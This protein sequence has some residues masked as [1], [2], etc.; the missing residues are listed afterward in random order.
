[1]ATPDTPLP[2]L[3][4][5]A[6]QV[7][8][9]AARYRLDGQLAVSPETLTVLEIAV[10]AWDDLFR[11]ASVQIIVTDGAALRLD[12]CLHL[13]PTQARRLA[14]HL[15]AA[16]QGQ[17]APKKSEAV[18]TFNRTSGPYGFLSN[19]ARTPLRLKETIWPTV[20]HYY[21]AQKFAGTEHEQLIRLAA[22]PAL[23]AHL[24]RDRTRPLRPDWPDVRLEVMREALRAK[25]S[26][27]SR[28]RRQLLA[29]GSARL[30]ERTRRDAYWGDGGDGRGQNHLGRLLMQL[31]DQLRKE[32]ANDPAA[33]P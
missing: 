2:R 31:R 26:Q 3:L 19:F 28:L 25:F 27:H 8:A 10:A 16:C 13:P 22:S 7:L 17:T 12:A 20:E 5:A 18:I 11:T 6:R 23:A 4:T 32:V 29:T 30:V 9:D 14:D 33:Q 21:Q 15:I 1:M 24:G